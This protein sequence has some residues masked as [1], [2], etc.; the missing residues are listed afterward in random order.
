[1]HDPFTSGAPENPADATAVHDARPGLL[2]SSWRGGM[3]GFRRSS[4]VA[5]PMAV[6]LAIPG[7]AVTLFAGGSGRG[8]A[9]PAHLLL[10]WAICGVIIVGGCL[11]GAFLGLVGAVFR[12]ALPA[13]AGPTIGDVRTTE[14]K[15]SVFDRGSLRPRRSRLRRMAVKAGVIAP[16]AFALAYFFGIYSGGKVDRELASA[17]AVADRDDP[18]W[19]LGDVF[20]HRALVPDAENSAPVV[21]K[22][23]ALMPENM[24]D[25]VTR[26]F[27]AMKTNQEL[28]TAMTENVCLDDALADSLRSELNAC[29]EAV[30]V[31]RTLAGY[32]RGRYELKL[33]PTIFDTPLPGLTKTNAVARL[34]EA[35]SAIRA[36]DQDT[37][38][39]LD[40]CRAI[41][42][43]SRSVGDEPFLISQL[44]R[45]GK[46]IEAL[47]ATRR[48]LAQGQPSERAL[49]QI[50]E[51][52][53]D[54][55]AQPLIQYGLKGERA[56]HVEIIRRIG[57]GEVT[58]EELSKDTSKFDPHRLRDAVTPWSRLWF[59]HER[60][61][62]LEWMNDANNVENQPSAERRALW[63]NFENRFNVKQNSA[64][65]WLT[66]LPLKLFPAV[67][68]AAVAHARLRADLGA[69]AILVAAER[70]RQTV[71][72]WPE[73][74]AAIDKRF[75]SKA[76]LD[77][78]TGEPFRMDHHDG[79]LLIY[80]IGGNRKDE[81]GDRK[82]IV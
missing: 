61:V 72:K 69:T 25:G 44:V 18:H 62:M 57:A 58:L 27:F 40:S 13:S 30:L 34:L 80:S 32:D 28:L 68:S 33:G 19:R 26:T 7:F 55:L 60:A 24:P 73:S 22:A 77:P 5:A 41:F 4:Y 45:I 79:E 12:L 8:W 37:D 78:Y 70:H 2:R 50:Q 82:S 59:D 76:P 74:I 17:T 42:G 3:S 43:A 52:L 75:L 64:A 56:S 14:I 66:L 81:R 71:G 1:M 29:H 65:F 53:L 10:G 15:A 31:A 36:H 35:D 63:A 46:G 11:I 39:A 47:K 48:V 16:L 38:G 51:L 54:E 67:R 49:T 9:V 23:A 21:L 6:L 20:A